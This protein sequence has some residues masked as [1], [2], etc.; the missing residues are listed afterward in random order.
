VS[1][2]VLIE[3]FSTRDLFNIS[4]IVADYSAVVYSDS[5]NP[6]S[7]QRTIT[8]SDTEGLVTFEISYTDS[9]GR[10]FSQTL[11]PEYGHNVTIGESGTS[12]CLFI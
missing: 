11:V 6:Y 7:F 10:E 12:L 3:F 4:L 5:S 1:D 9:S 8:S 2:V